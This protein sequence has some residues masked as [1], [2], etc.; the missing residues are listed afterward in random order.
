M[1]A[2]RD[3]DQNDADE[4]EGLAQPSVLL[5]RK[6]EKNAKKRDVNEIIFLPKITIFR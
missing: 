5:I 4:L 2:L 3:L 1:A 6:T